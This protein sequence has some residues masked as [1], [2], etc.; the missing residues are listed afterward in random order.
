MIRPH[1]LQRTLLF[2][3]LLILGCSSKEDAAPIE[4]GYVELSNGGVREERH[5]GR[6]IRPVLD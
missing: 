3:T 5:Y 6:S 1:S 2:A 4:R